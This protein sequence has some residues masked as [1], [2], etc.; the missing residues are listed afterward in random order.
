[1][2]KGNR[3]YYIVL[4]T[5]F[6]AVITLQY[7][8]PKPINWNR[9]Y[10]KKDKIPFGCFAIY[11]LLETNFAQKIK[12]NNQTL[13]NLNSETTESNQTL[14]IIDNKVEFSKVDVKSL[15]SYL[16]KGNNVL[17]ATSQI[18]KT[19]AD[20]FKLNIEEN[21]IM[22]SNSLDSLLTKRAFEIHYT[23][24]KNNCLTCQ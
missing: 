23:Q 16:K 6:A 4:A 14:L 20:T 8:Q 9:T 13:Y 18:N 1:M 21:W 17:I 11:N 3:K 5:V 7:L 12:N 24:P 2:F 19:L 10:F 22:K 15:F